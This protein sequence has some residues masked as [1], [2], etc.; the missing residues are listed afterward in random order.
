MQ[1]SV[2]YFRQKR[3]L[4][5]ANFLDLTPVTRHKHEEE[6]DGTIRLL[7]PR[8]TG[9]LLGRWLQRKARH[10]YMTLSLDEY[11]T[12]TWLLCDGQ[13]TV[14]DICRRMKDRFGEKVHP[15]EDRI[16]TFLSQLYKKKLITFRELLEP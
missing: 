4:S 15:A 13:H 5:N 7:I 6:G 14:R 8:F 10:P 1:K 2:G 16:T 3:I 9:A 12:A 11:G